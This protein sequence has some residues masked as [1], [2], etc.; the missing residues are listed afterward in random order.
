MQM[1]GLRV[2]FW[3]TGMFL[4]N[5]RFVPSIISKLQEKPQLFSL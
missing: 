3:R 4:S 1:V 2:Q 5:C